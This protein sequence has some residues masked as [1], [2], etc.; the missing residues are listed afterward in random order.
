MTNFHGFHATI[1]VV[2]LTDRSTLELAANLRAGITKY[3]IANI[4]VILVAT[5]KI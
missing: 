5:K 3:G 2:D 4:P 1:L